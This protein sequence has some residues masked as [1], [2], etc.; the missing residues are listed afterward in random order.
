MAIPLMNYAPSS[1]SQRVA[2]FEVPGDENLM[3]YST[4]IA[5]SASNLDKVICTKARSFGGE[6][7]GCCWS[8]YFSSWYN[9]CSFNSLGSN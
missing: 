4:K 6:D 7:L 3:I 9:S 5:D 8:K 2:D 1:Q